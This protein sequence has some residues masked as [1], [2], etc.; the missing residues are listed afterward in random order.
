VIETERLTFRKYKMDDLDFYYSMLADPEMMRY[1]GNG[2]TKNLGES[3]EKLNLIINNYMA[4]NGLGI[5]L[6]CRKDDGALIGHVGFVPQ[7][8]DGT[9]QVEL[10]YWIA[11]KYWGKGYGTEAAK[12]FLNYGLY[13][14]GI[15]ELI[16]IIQKGNAPSINIARKIGMKFKKDIVYYS[17]NVAI[18]EITK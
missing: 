6:A 4:Y 8:I 2:K 13:T 12:A 17:K 5:M 11:Q 18:Y 9:V 3:K 15:D 7:K 1:I 14:L 10:G 16:S